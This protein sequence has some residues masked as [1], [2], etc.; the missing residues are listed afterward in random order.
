MVSCLPLQRNSSNCLIWKTH[1]QLGNY[2]CSPRKN[3][4]L[5]AQHIYKALNKSVCQIFQHVAYSLRTKTAIWIDI[6]VLIYGIVIYAEKVSGWRV[7]YGPVTSLQ[8]DT[9]ETP[10]TKAADATAIQRMPADINALAILKTFLTQEEMTLAHMNMS[11]LLLP[12]NKE[13]TWN[14]YDLKRVQYTINKP[15]N[16]IHVKD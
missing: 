9:L 4:S 1:R 6:L 16:K 11:W 14:T 12:I 2:L 7:N 13:D 8:M 5:T 15:S 3:Y 10:A